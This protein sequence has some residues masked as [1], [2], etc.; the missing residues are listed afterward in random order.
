[1][2]LPYVVSQA[3]W[4]AKE[5]TETVELK[6]DFERCAV[7]VIEIATT[8]FS[9]TID[10]QGKLHELGSYANVPYIRQDQ[11]S[12]Q[13]PSV[14]QISYTTNTSTYRYVILGYWRRLQL[15][16]T[17]SA[18]SITCGVAG[19]SDA[20]VFPFVITTDTNSAAMLT[21]LQ[22]IDNMISGNEAQVDVVGALPAGSALI[23]KV[24]IDQTTPGTTNAVARG[25]A[26]LLNSEVKSV[27]AAIKA[28]AG[29]VY[30]ITVS[31]TAALA[32][33][34]NDSTAGAG[35]DV[36]ALDL[37]AGGYGHFIFDP[38]IECATGIYLDVSTATCKVTIGYK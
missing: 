20:K 30:W 26:T 31:D 17:R 8:G 13:T 4:S 33:E 1:M 37:P 3:I 35:T 27:D 36:W 22:I 14:A 23:G 19:S 18:G 9:G 38:P 16:M 6:S 21:A 15:V 25:P 32:I 34:I 2:S 5:A 11:S 29:K 28:S 24:G 12:I 10:I 7:T